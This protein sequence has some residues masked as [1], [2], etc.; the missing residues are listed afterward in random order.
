M[1]CL[2]MAAMS[3][4]AVLA[5]PAAADNNIPF[6]GTIQSV[7]TTF[8]LF[9]PDVPFP[10]L[11]VEGSGSGHATH[12]GEYSVTFEFEVNLD[13]F[14]AFGSYH[15]IAANGDSIFTDIVGLGTVPTEDGVSFLVVTHTIIGGT[16]RFEGA[17]GSFTEE[18]VLNVFTHVKSGSFDGSIVLDKA[19]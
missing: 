9:P 5:G 19:K 13:A 15:F 4:T 14:V 12:L 8:A 2:Q 10:T 11:F 17:T 18:S 1:L 3:L 16:G 7:E 6:K